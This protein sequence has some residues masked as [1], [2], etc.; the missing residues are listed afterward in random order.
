VT[1]QNEPVQLEIF[2]DV[3]CP[4]CYIG[5]TKLAEAV[6]EFTAAGGS[7]ELRFRPYLLQPDFRGSSRPL[8]DYLTERFGSQAG[9]LSHSATR[10]GAEVGLDMRMEQALIADTRPAHQLIEVAYRHGGFPTQQVVANELF[11]SHFN[12][13]EDVADRAILERAGHRANLTADQITEALDDP[14][15]A[16]TVSAGLVEAQ[17]L[18]ITAVPTFVA[19]RAIG[20]AGAQP[21]ATLLALLEKAAETKAA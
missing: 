8:S 11:L 3:I 2:S 6:T 19:N 12:R 18:G 21:P 1:E 17:Q 13:G 9:Q 7:V 16:A 4:W 5:K 14:D 15:V 20:V 10:A